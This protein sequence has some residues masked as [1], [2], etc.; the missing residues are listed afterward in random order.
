MMIKTLAGPT[1]HSTPMSRRKSLIRC[2][3][4]ACLVLLLLGVLRDAAIAE[5]GYESSAHGVAY[6]NGTGECTCTKDG[7]PCADSTWFTSFASTFDS[8]MTG[9][10]AYD[11]TEKWTNQQVD[12]VDIVDASR[13]AYGADEVDPYG[14]DFADAIFTSSHGNAVCS[15][16]DYRS[17]FGLGQ[18]HSGQTCWPETDHDIEWGDT[19]ADVAIIFGCQSVQLC[20]WDHNTY[21]PMDAGSFKMLMGFHGTMWLNSDANGRLDDFLADTATDDIGEYWVDYLTDIQFWPW[22]NPDQC[23]TTVLWGSTYGAMDDMYDYGGFK[24][25][26]GTGTHSLSSFYS[27]NGCD[28]HDGPEL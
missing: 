28:P 17:S 24:D 26:W 14:T 21:A 3:I 18:A 10:L 12:P 27:Y 19:D 4:A 22:E 1:A 25:F 8:R 6:Y 7:S 20:V 11:Q 2:G 13:E 5:G 23:A 9:S 15:G 16:S